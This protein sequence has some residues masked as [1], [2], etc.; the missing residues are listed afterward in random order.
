MRI[1]RT[2]VVATSAVALGV[3]AYVLWLGDVGVPGLG[4]AR[5]VG[6]V[7]LALGWLASAVAVVPS[8]GV[9]IH[10]SKLYLAVTS[11]LGVLALVA[12]I[13]VLV[14]GS[15]GMLA[16]LVTATVVMWA[17]ATVR[18]TLVAA[19]AEQGPSGRQNSPREKVEAGR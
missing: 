1:N 13:A 17:M 15:E 6:G 2:D 5:V 16:L 12:G 3:A 7:V 4:S 11:A 18:H 14:T 9:L 8:F 19:A 10:S